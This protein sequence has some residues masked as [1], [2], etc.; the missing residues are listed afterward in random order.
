MVDFDLSEWTGDKKKLAAMGIALLAIVAAGYVLLGSRGTEVATVQITASGKAVPGAYAVVRLANGETKL[1]GP[2]NEEGILKIPGKARILAIKTPDGKKIQTNKLVQPGEIE[3]I[4]FQPPFQKDVLFVIM[5]SDVN[6]AEIKI[7]VDGNTVFQRE[8]NGNQ[9]TV[10]FGRDFVLTP[11]ST[12]TIEVNA[13]GF[14]PWIISTTGEELQGVYAITLDSTVPEVPTGTVEVVATRNGRPFRGSVQLYQ[15]DNMIGEKNFDAGDVKF[16]AIPYGVYVAKLL[17]DNGAFVAKKAFLLNTPQTIVEFKVMPPPTEEENVAGTPSSG[18]TEENGVIVIGGEGG[19]STSI[20]VIGGNEASALVIAPLGAEASGEGSAEIQETDN[21][22]LVFGLRPIPIIPKAPANTEN[23]AQP[24]VIETTPPSEGI[25]ATAPYVTPFWEAKGPNTAYFSSNG[26]E[27]SIMD[28]GVFAVDNGSTV[29]AYGNDS[30]TP[31]K[32]HVQDSTGAPIYHAV[33]TVNYGDNAVK[34][35][36]NRSGNATIGIHNGKCVSMS[37]SAEGYDPKKD[38]TVC[39]SDGETT[40]TLN[41]AVEKGDIR[42]VVKTFKGSRAPQAEVSISG[43]GYS[44]QK[45]AD[46]AGVVVF[47]DVPVGKYK[48]TATWGG[49]SGSTVTEVE[50]GTTRRATVVVYAGTG[51]LEFHI[52]VDGKPANGTITI[53][54]TDTGASLGRY[55]LTN[56]EAAVAVPAEIPLGYKVSVGGKTLTGYSKLSANGEEEI[57]VNLPRGMETGVWLESMKTN[58]QDT[59]TL[60]PG[61]ATELGLLIG[62]KTGG[63]LH[64]LVTPTAS[65]DIEVPYVYAKPNSYVYA[66]VWVTPSEVAGDKITLKAVLGD[67]KKEITLPV[68]NTF[69]CTDGFCYHVGL[70]KNECHVGETVNMTAELIYV[71][72]DEYKGKAGIYVDNTPILEKS[73][74]TRG[75]YVWARKTVQPNRTDTWTVKFRAGSTERQ[76]DTIHVS[77]KQDMDFTVSPNII[78]PIPTEQRITVTV[79]TPDGVNP[80]VVQ[81]YIYGKDNDGEHIIAHVTAGDTAIIRI[82]NADKYN[83]LFLNA[84]SSRY[85]ITHG[86]LPMVGKDDVLTLNQKNVTLGNKKRNALVRV[87]TKLSVPVTVK[88][89]ASANT[90]C[91]AKLRVKPNQVSLEP[92]GSSELNV[93]YTGADRC[94]RSFSGSADVMAYVPW[95][96]VPVAVKHANVTVNPTGQC[97]EIQAPDETSL[98]ESGSIPIRVYNRCD[99][100]VTV[101]LTVECKAIKGVSDL[102]CGFEREHFWETPQKEQTFTLIGG[103]SKKLELNYS[104]GITGTY[105]VAEFNLTAT[106]GENVEKVNKTIYAW[107]TAWKRC[108]SV[109]PHDVIS[110]DFGEK[111][112]EISAAASVTIT[113]SEDCNVHV[114]NLWVEGDMGKYAKIKN[115]GW[116]LE[117]M[118][119]ELTVKKTFQD[120]IE[121][122]GNDMNLLIKPLS[123]VLKID[124]NA[125]MFNPESGRKERKEFNIPITLVNNVS[126]PPDIALSGDCHF[127]RGEHNAIC[128]VTATI[129]DRDVGSALE[130]NM[131]EITC[132]TGDGPHKT[133]L[134]CGWRDRSTIWVEY[135]ADTIVPITNKGIKVTGSLKLKE[136]KN[137]AL[138]VGGTLSIPNSVYKGAPSLEFK[139]CTTENCEY[140][141]VETITVP[142]FADK[143]V[144]YATVEDG[145]VCFQ[146]GSCSQEANVYEGS[147]IYIKSSETNP[148]LYIY[149]EVKGVPVLDDSFKGTVTGVYWIKGNGEKG[150]TIKATVP[151]AEDILNGGGILTLTEP[152]TMVSTYDGYLQN[153]RGNDAE[154]CSNNFC[155]TSAVNSIVSQIAKSSAWNGS[156]VELLAYGERPEKPDRCKSGQID[157]QNNSFWLVTVDKGD[158]GSCSVEINGL[159]SKD[160]GLLGAIAEMANGTEDIVQHKDGSDS[161]EKEIQAIIG[162]LGKSNSSFSSNAEMFIKNTPY[163]YVPILWTDMTYTQKNLAKEWTITELVPGDGVKCENANNDSVHIFEKGDDNILIGAP[164]ADEDSLKNV[165]KCE[166]GDAKTLYNLENVHLN[167][168]PIDYTTDI[169]GTTYEY[170]PSIRAILAKIPEYIMPH[171]KTE[172]NAPPLCIHFLEGFVIPKQDIYVVIKKEGDTWGAEVYR[173]LGNAE[174]KYPGLLCIDNTKLDAVKKINDIYKNIDDEQRAEAHYNPFIHTMFL[175]QGWN[176]IHCGETNCITF[177]YI[178]SSDLQEDCSDKG[179]KYDDSKIT[180]QEAVS[181]NHPIGKRQGKYGYCGKKEYLSIGDVPLEWTEGGWL[182]DVEYTNQPHPIVGAIISSEPPTLKPHADSWACYWRQLVLPIFANDGE[183]YSAL[184]IGSS[185]PSTQDSGS[186]DYGGD[187]DYDRLKYY[188]P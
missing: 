40:I 11:K 101:K 113:R 10:H 71:G 179:T 137:T 77:E 69:T 78:L 122:T 158:N 26:S 98:Q 90:G 13:D 165:V 169:P 159:N 47:K 104:A 182:A 74:W 115:V 107:T 127:N 157:E 176:N 52:S 126:A 42:V 140:N 30:S 5:N 142:D 188:G 81:Y 138:N 80:G 45:R 177:T 170:D 15:S 147:E 60:S 175:G 1:V 93:Y 17:D 135:N 20:S 125:E 59:I 132:S 79:S 41:K 31:V 118:N 167:S 64:V 120:S 35:R 181:C 29:T 102:S 160:G 58:N 28:N 100:P 116:W 109:S 187:T 183:Q 173:N 141:E 76:I 87:S 131:A 168:Y 119:M 56:G 154:D 134:K 16:G 22:P 55:P 180:A 23:E 6:G 12:I 37:V 83:M 36:T 148:V 136:L 166:Y 186:S 156:H 128:P 105:P 124:I 155:P 70:S 4:S 46:D 86:Q 72:Q 178:V 57:R 89:G 139:N 62:T 63:V 65:A 14:K 51:K 44:D 114:V 54:R 103:E 73:G 38:I 67:A 27:E 117:K 111:D 146:G 121:I 18:Q 99:E 123:G 92:K 162:K 171:I 184:N 163:G 108:V 149:P 164:D 53:T 8:M 88:T 25:I 61:N 172:L 110:L 39:A 152:K 24:T 106:G 112:G 2:A 34:R 48:I 32:V 68:G 95:L 7:T 143:G 84:E 49:W 19:K 91:G 43:D 97:I 130:L 9:M 50:K 150:I 85:R 144:V 133:E 82:R 174:K 3:S 33:I 129:L 153:R 151:T 96:S 161:I 94:A 145:K 66:K 21:V 185:T 75:E